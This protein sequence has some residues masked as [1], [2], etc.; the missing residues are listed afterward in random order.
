MRTGSGPGL[1]AHMAARTAYVDAAVLAAVTDGLPQ[2]VV[3]GAGYDD[4]AL[5]FRTPGVTF[6]EIDHP[7]TQVDKRE[8]VRQL[9]AAHDVQFVP[10]DLRTDDVAAELAEAGQN[11]DVPTLFVCEGL[12]LYLSQSDVRRL[13]LALRERAAPG[14]RQVASLAIHA[15]GVDSEAAVAVANGRRRD[16]T[17]EPWFT[18]LSRDEHLRLLADSGWPVTAA[19][20]VPSVTGGGGSL[21]VESRI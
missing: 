8:R 12:L 15:D 19:L 9:G 17:A 14:S 6:Y 1:R 5:R 7:A 16:A 18:I 10:A 20:D 2:V 4:R 21:L 11:L 3:V 13:L